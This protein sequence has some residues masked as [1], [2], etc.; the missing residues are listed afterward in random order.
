MAKNVNITLMIN[1]LKKEHPILFWSTILGLI[2]GGI[3]L[4]YMWLSYSEQHTPKLEIIEPRFFSQLISDGNVTGIMVTVVNQ[5]NAW[6][7]NV[8]IDFINDNGFSKYARNKYYAKENRVIQPKEISPNGKD[9]DGYLPQGAAASP[10]IYQNNEKKYEVDIFIDWENDKG[11][12]Y[13][14]VSG[15]ESIADNFNK[16]VQFKRVYKYDTFKN[17]KK[18]KEMKNINKA[19]LENS[20][21]D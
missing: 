17:K 16:H 21:M 3:G 8:M 9:Y 11:D 20:M 18:V 5:S 4:W 13:S 14:L 19:Y 15:Y 1:S 6:A 7:K 12:K 2:I 10:V